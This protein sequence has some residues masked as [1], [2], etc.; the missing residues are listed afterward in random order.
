MSQDADGAMLIYLLWIAYIYACVWSRNNQ[1]PPHDRG[2]SKTVIDANLAG[3]AGQR[4]DPAFAPLPSASHRTGIAGDTP[5]IAD[6]LSEIER[7]DSSFQI[8]AFLQGA[9]AAYEAITVA[10]AKGDRAML[11]QLVSNDVYEVFLADIVERERRSERAEVAFV[12]IAPPEI[13]EV[14]ICG[15]EVEIS[16]RF[17]SELFSVVHGSAGAVVRGSPRKTVKADDIWIFAKAI[18]S[19][20]PTWRLIASNPA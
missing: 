16:M 2:V 4:L 20:E 19:S 13:V 6:V 18:P 14:R 15:N 9:S 7:R 11:R 3:S 5:T 1:Y 8:T 17:I 12:R 10:Y